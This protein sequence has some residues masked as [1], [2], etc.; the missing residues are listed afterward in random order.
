MNIT[1]KV[2]VI[3]G[4]I[5]LN[6]LF[7]MFEMAMV[8]ARQLKLKKYEAEGD[9]RAKRTL[10]MLDSP[11]EFLSTVQIGISLISNLSGAFGGASIS[12]QLAA[13]FREV[14]VFGRSTDA[15]ALIVVVLVI[16]FFSIVL[17]ELVPK[18]VALNNPEKVSMSLSGIMGFFSRLSTPIAVLLSAATN[19]VMKL[20][21]VKQTS[22]PTITE[23]EVRQLIEEGRM[24]GV[25]NQAEQSMVEGVFRFADRRMDALM[26]PRTD[27]DWIDL[28]DSREQMV[29]DI[30]ASKY[31]RL[32]LAKGDL[33]DIIGMVSTKDLAGENIFSLDFRFEEIAKPPLF[34]PESTSAV[35]AFEQFR[36]TGIHEALVIDEFGSV[37]GMVTLFDVLES[38]TGE[39]PGQDQLT[40]LEV[41]LR[42]DGSWS[43]DGLLPTDELKELLE[44][45]ELPDE[46]RV[47]YQTLSGFVMHMLGRIPEIGETFDVDGFRFE[48]LDMDSLRVDRVLVTEIPTGEPE[49]D[50]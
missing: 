15:V 35:A 38:I 39:I 7:S 26:T 36:Q 1:L 3:L 24:T 17:G 37:R 45:H 43:L 20:L 11:N 46:D 23:M 14:G 2:V 27:I 30:K 49:A 48:V 8:S 16:T 6:G 12:V 28:D 19:L 22:E 34:I 32:P 33:D 41:F 10:D 18:R 5:L 25:F 31:S 29:R 42:P 13:W 47:G 50:R 4:L 21:G 40:N 44:L 9:Q